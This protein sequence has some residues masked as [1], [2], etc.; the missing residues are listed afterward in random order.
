MF[1]NFLGYF[2]F[3]HAGFQINEFPNSENYKLCSSGISDFQLVENGF[4]A[5]G[6]LY[7]S[8]FSAELTAALTYS[9]HFLK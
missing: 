4:I 9:Q 6:L 1:L 7:F 3:E 8:H 2:C 5:K